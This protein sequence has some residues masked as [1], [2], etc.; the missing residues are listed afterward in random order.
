MS[1][2][3]QYYGTKVNDITPKGFVTLQEF[4]E[5]QM[6][7][8]T[9]QLFEKIALAEATGNMQLKAKLKQENLRA[10]TPCVII[11]DY[12]PGVK[13]YAPKDHW[14]EN[15]QWKDYAHIQD[16]TGLAVLDFDHL[17][18]QNI[19]AADLKNEL[20]SQYN[21]IILAWV[22]P[23]Q[24]GVKA[25]VSIPKVKTVA[26][27]QQYHAG[28]AEEFSVIPGWDN[29]T[30][31]P[32]LSLFQ[33]YDEDL[34]FRMDYAT[35]TTVGKPPISIFTQNHPP[36]VIKPNNNVGKERRIILKSINTGFNNISKTSGGHPLLLR[37]SVSVGGYIAGGY[38][39]ESEAI[40]LM[41]Y[42]ITS[43]PYLCKGISGY[44][45][46]MRDG[47]YLGQQKPIVL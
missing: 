1:F 46:T 18:E 34:C 21:C 33:S 36:I 40:E 27:F 44:K 32:T 7:T 25:I 31:N 13:D 22:S 28:L 8:N 15:V 29:T 2:K 4:A 35:W 9:K 14:K 23:S 26:E 17:K 10:Y 45:K 6:A 43:H 24:N 12:K 16:F 20:F 38:I 30:K 3:F 42:L 41:D 5:L 37:L 39:S 19:S 47:I 11:G